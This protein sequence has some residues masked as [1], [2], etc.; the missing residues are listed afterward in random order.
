MFLGRN[1]GLKFLMNVIK[2]IICVSIT[3]F[4]IGHLLQNI[5]MILY[6]SY[7]NISLRSFYKKIVILLFLRTNC[8]LFCFY[9]R[10][11]YSI[12]ECNSPIQY[13]SS[14]VTT[15]KKV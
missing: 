11:F 6:A 12:V 13:H 10:R 8:Y 2:I 7:Y 4:I 5:S 9:F 1:G 15:H 3:L 14:F